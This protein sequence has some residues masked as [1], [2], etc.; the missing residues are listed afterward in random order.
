ATLLAELPD[1]HWGDG[2]A[3]EPRRLP[4]DHPA[5]E[6]AFDSVH[7]D[8]GEG[9]ERAIDVG[10]ALSDEDQ[11]R[12]RGGEPRHALGELRALDPHVERAAHVRLAVGRG[13]PQLDHAAA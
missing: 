4:L 12:A 8:A 9:L 10:R 1:R 2:R 6:E 7:T 11:R 5:L 3:L 13:L